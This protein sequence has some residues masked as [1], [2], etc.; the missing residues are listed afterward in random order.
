MI[1]AQ[2]NVTAKQEQTVCYEAKK[3]KKFNWFNEFLLLLLLLLL[4]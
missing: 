2:T 1:L 4:F 3:D